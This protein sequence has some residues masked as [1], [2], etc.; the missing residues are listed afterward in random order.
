[1]L[2]LADYKFVSVCA[3]MV[4]VVYISLVCVVV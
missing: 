1:M 4:S 2:A 3:L